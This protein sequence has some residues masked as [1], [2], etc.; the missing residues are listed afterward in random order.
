ME[1]TKNKKSKFTVIPRTRKSTIILRANLNLVATLQDCSADPITASVHS[2]KKILND[3]LRAQKTKTGSARVK[4]KCHSPAENIHESVHD[5]IKLT[6]TNTIPPPRTN[7]E[8]ASPKIPN[9]SNQP[10]IT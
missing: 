4:N 5:E 1:K 7:T 3:I 6:P 9:S 8:A 2:L 10:R